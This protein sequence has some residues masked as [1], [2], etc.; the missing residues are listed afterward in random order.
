MAKI[1]LGLVIVMITFWTLWFAHRSAVASDTTVSYYDFENAFPMADGLL[2]AALLAS[3][4]SLWTG[5]ATAVLFGLLGAGGGFYLFGMDLLFDIEHG[6]W[7]RGAGG[8]IE[9]VI[10]ILTIVASVGFA[11]WMWVNRRELDPR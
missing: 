11:R 1:L 2:T 5:R 4:W 7:G 6:I 10:N 3:A 8:A 9:L